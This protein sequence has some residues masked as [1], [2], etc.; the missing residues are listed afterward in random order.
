[1]ISI[2]RDG[3]NL[4][5]WVGISGTVTNCAG[6]PTPWGTWLTCEETENAGD[7]GG[8]P[9]GGSKDHGYVFE[10]WGDGKTAHPVPIKALGRY[11]HEA[12]AVDKDRNHV[13]LSEDASGPNGL[14]YRWTAPPGAGSGRDRWP[15][16]RRP[17]AR[18]RRCRSSGTTAGRCRTSPT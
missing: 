1:M 6:G 15:A 9:T 3:S 5:E 8:A 16:R 7:T 11:A 10:V 14:F 2:D 13:Y 12:F 18:S 17:P 4:G